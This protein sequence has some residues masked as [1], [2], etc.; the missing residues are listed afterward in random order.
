MP[1]LRGAEEVLPASQALCALTERGALAQLLP[2]LQ[3][4]VAQQAFRL[5][6]AGGF[7]LSSNLRHSVQHS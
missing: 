2:V 7:H 3:H 4:T 5:R 1:H 6:V